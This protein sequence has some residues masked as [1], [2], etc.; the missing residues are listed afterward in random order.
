MI[1][2]E[3]IVTEA[4]TWIGTRYVH[5]ASVK[6]AGCD[7]IG[8]VAGVAE[9][10]GLPE[11]KAWKLDHRYRGYAPTPVANLLVDACDVYL[12]KITPAQARLGDVML[13]AFMKLPMHFG[14]ISQ[15]RHELVVMCRASTLMPMMVI[16]AYAPAKKVVENSIDAKW[17]NRIVGAYR[18]RGKV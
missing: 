10:L 14:I 3:Q 17:L 1:T 7:C 11:A 16:H 15:E 12:D 8:L 4:R 13:F 2:G 18:Y 9:A 6:G 5:Q